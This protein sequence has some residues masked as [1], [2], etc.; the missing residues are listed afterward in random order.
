MKEE[1]AE[2]KIE[3]SPKFRRNRGG[4]L[5]LAYLVHLAVPALL[6]L[7]IV[8][9]SLR[10]E[11][12]FKA[13]SLVTV[14]GVVSAVWLVGGLVLFFAS[15]D[16]GALLNRLQTPLTAVYAIFF[17]V[18]LM[19][20]YLRLMGFNEPIRG[21]SFYRRT[22][23]ADPKV[24]PGVSGVKRYTINA[25]GLRGPM[26]PI[27]NSNYK[28]IAIGASTTI[29]S[30]LDDSE[31]WPHLVMQKLNAGQQ[32]RHVWV[33]NAGVAG[34][35]TVSHLVMM[36]WYPGVLHTDMA[37]FL[38]GV[39][40]LTAT[41]A[42]EGAPTQTFLERAA[43]FEGDL[44]AG[45]HWRS[46]KYYPVY[47]QARIFVLVRLAQK[48]LNQRL[49][50]TPTKGTPLPAMVTLRQRRAASS[51]L[52]IPDVS[53]GLREYAT[54]IGSLADRCTDLKMRCL[55]LTQPTM[56]RENLSAREDSLFWQGYLGRFANPK[57]YISSPD[58]ARAMDSYN[59]TL[60]DVCRQRGLEC[61]DMAAHIPKDTSAFYD[62][63]HFNE[64][65]A[66]LVANNLTEYL[67]A[68][69]PFNSKKD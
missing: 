41:L 7:D 46:L 29:C 15:R 20:G 55:F 48:N 16:R 47:R 36:Q 33:G 19:E 40:D 9:A 28:I 53:N 61:F 26:P 67:L 57:G 23:T 2:R 58:M 52:P 30:D 13:T 24:L 32:T 22:M 6:L 31:E 63:M 69:A 3:E 56:W 43:G 49:H 1:T 25:L 50:H 39:N 27:V 11:V 21:E 38:I 60:L 44:P 34:E 68:R 45:T 42:Y 65:G 64:N 12:T 10:H 54:R 14:V 4:I 17:S 51:V 8:N 35:N 37:I 18:L 62:E 59:R 66:R 5:P